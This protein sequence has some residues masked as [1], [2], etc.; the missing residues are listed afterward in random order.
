MKLEVYTPPPSPPQTLKLKLEQAP[1]VIILGLVDETGKMIPG[2]NILFISDQ[3]V[4]LYQSI[5]SSFGLPLDK[6]GKIKLI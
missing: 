1:G 6:D 2:G 4:R 5:H 3:G